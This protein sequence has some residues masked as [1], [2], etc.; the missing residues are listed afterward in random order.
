MTEDSHGQWEIRKPTVLLS[1]RINNEGTITGTSGTAQECVLD[2][3]LFDEPLLDFDMVL[4]VDGSAYIDQSTGKKHVGFAVVDVEGDIEVIQPLPE[5]LSAQQ[6]EL[7]VLKTD[8]ELGA[9]KALTV[10][11]DSAYASGVWRARGFT[12]RSGLW[13]HLLSGMPF[14][15]STMIFNM[16]RLAHGVSH[17]SKG[18]FRRRFRRTR[19]FRR[20]RFRPNGFA[21]IWISK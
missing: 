12:N 16:C 11:S 10:Y 1:P 4:F 19:R 3:D 14:L 13:L 6:A 5:H 17:S 9:R 2:E 8:C 7:L 15:P 21:K 18:E 20:R